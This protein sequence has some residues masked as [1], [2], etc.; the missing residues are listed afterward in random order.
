MIAGFGRER[1]REGGSLDVSQK[2]LGIMGGVVVGSPLANFQTHSRHTRKLANTPAHNTEECTHTHT[3][4]H[5]DPDKHGHTSLNTS[6]HTSI[7]CTI[8]YM[9]APKYSILFH[10]QS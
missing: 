4:T 6:M 10:K 7:L 2:T 8:L 5:R 9:Y 1:Q 3:D